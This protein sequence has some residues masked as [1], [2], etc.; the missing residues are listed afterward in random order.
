MPP[1]VN[2]YDTT[3]GDQA[4]ALAKAWH[5]SDIMGI[6]TASG[7]PIAAASNIEGWGSEQVLCRQCHDGAGRVQSYM[8]CLDS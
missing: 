1:P 3:L 8:S 4:I 2:K 7:P 6:G 5:T